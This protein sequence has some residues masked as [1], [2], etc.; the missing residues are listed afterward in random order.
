VSFSSGIF[1]HY[2]WLVHDHGYSF[3]LG[4]V[5]VSINEKVSVIMMPLGA[6]SR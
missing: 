5:E 6:D 4:G 3:P 1:W 2:R